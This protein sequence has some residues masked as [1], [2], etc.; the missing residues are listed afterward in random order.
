MMKMG[1][2]NRWKLPD[3]GGSELGLDFLKRSD[4][5][6]ELLEVIET[7]DEDRNVGEERDCDSERLKGKRVWV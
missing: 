7:D 3:L 6:V 2:K 4:V 5:I 1:N